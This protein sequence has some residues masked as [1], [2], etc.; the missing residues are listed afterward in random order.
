MSRR[1]SRASLD[2][3]QNDALFEFENFKKKFLL[4]NKHITKL[5]STLSVR[6]EELNA[7][8]STLYTENLRLRASEIALATQLKREREKSRQIIAETEVAANGVL[9]A[10]GLTKHLTFLRQ[11]FNITEQGPQSPSPTPPKAARRL[12]LQSNSSP[13]SP[14]ATKLSRVPTVPKIHEDAEPSPSSEEEPEE[15][16][17]VKL[18]PRRRAKAKARLSASRLPL[19]SRIASPPP[20]EPSTSSVPLQIDFESIPQATSKRKPSRRQSGLVID[21]R[22]L[23]PDSAGFIPRPSSPAYGS[24]IR[25]AAGLAEERD[26]NA[27]A[28]M[29]VD[30]NN[31]EG[32]FEEAAML[33]KKPKSSSKKEKGAT[34]AEFVEK[35]KAKLREDNEVFLNEGA[36]KKLKL[37]DVTNSPQRSPATAPMDAAAI[38]ELEIEP[39]S[40]RTSH[41]PTPSP[42]PGEQEAD[43]TADGRER[44]TR[45][46]VNYAEPKLNT[47]MRKPDPPEGSAATTNRKRST[48]VRSSM[49]SSSSYNKI[50]AVEIGNS[51]ELA[52]ETPRSSLERDERPRSGYGGT[53]GM[54]GLPPSS[55]STSRR[56]RSRPILIDDD[57]DDDDGADAD[58]EYVPSLGRASWVNLGERRR[59]TSRRTT[60]GG[61]VSTLDE[62][63]H[64][65][66]L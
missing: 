1:E 52:M 10:L 48:G 6:I 18:S 43:A 62:R 8:I 41:L 58:E 26:E 56:N 36:R 29:H 45:K 38:S 63:R 53:S 14:V 28:G 34:V 59:G 3:R 2:A 9:Q 25:R 20:P 57:D 4:A 15:S 21:T 47:K 55:S 30:V 31:I 60:D 24:P 39:P 17:L 22:M 16:N 32:E 37:K 49:P 65:M 66:A 44:R 7:Q 12:V 11:A 54:S 5:N 23:G 46:S 51:E 42:P 61:I 27:A 64:S 40:S 50:Q 19:P 35:K 33:V 13:T